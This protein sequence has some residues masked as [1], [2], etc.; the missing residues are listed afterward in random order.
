MLNDLG[1]GKLGN[2]TKKNNGDK[3]KTAIDLEIQSIL[4][5]AEAKAKE[6]LIEN[7]TILMK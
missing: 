1:M 6:I 4:R 3:N 2:V 5:K 7:K